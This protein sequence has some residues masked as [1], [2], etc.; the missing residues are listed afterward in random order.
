MIC[1]K[2]NEE[3]VTYKNGQ[4]ECR[5]CNREYQSVWWNKNKI[6][7]QERVK[8]NRNR[9]Q[10]VILEIKECNKCLICAEDN[11]MVLEFDHVER[12][13]KRENVSDMVRIGI[14]PETIKQ[15]MSKCRV[16]CSNCHQ[17][18]TQIENNSYAYKKYE[19]DSRYKDKIEKIKS[20]FEPSQD[21]Q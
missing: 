18:K 21:S 7:Q 12:L 19:T 5:S 15:E 9:L 8:K 4:K 11:P 10:D 3:K 13:E 17:I 14:K 16:L 2:H 6:K 20:M 1:E